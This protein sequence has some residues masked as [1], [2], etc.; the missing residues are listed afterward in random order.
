MDTN[1]LRRCYNCHAS[2]S[3]SRSRARMEF[4]GYT[5]CSSTQ[6]ERQQTVTSQDAPIRHGGDHQSCN[7]VHFIAAIGCF[8][9]P[10]VHLRQTEPPFFHEAGLLSSFVCVRPAVLPVLLPTPVMRRV[11]GELLGFSPA[12]GIT[13]GIQLALLA[14]CSHERLTPRTPVA[15]R[16]QGCFV[17]TINLPLRGMPHQAV[18]AK[19]SVAWLGVVTTGDVPLDAFLVEVSVHFRVIEGTVDGCPLGLTWYTLAPR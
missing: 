17:R 16:L 6:I 1:L 11:E 15:L 4:G 13:P 19:P 14:A 9:R 8:V 2:H 5:G 12:T 3:R 10:V 7:V 18:G